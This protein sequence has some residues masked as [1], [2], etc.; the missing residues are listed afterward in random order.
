LLLLAALA[1]RV[2]KLHFG[3]TDVLPNFAPFMA[4]A[5]AGSILMPRQLAWWVWPVVLL[6]T[7]VAMQSAH[8]AEMSLVYV[9]YAVAALLGGLLRGRVGGFQ[10]VLGTAVCSLGF[11][12]ITSTQAWA[13]SAVYTKTLS[14]WL[15]AVTV[16]DPAYQPQAWMFL[17]K[18]LLSDVGFAVLL[19]AVYNREASARRVEGLPWV[20]AV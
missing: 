1:W 9:C 15:Q 4:L 12:L 20:V 5:F 17:V 6:A 8:I 14:G 16:G 18:A 3:V 19:L 10:A 13:V 7:D 11:Y 2:A